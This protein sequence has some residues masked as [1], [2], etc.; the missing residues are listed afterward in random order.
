MCRISGLAP[1]RRWFCSKRLPR[2]GRCGM[3][4]NARFSSTM[5]LLLA[6]AALLT[7]AVPARAGDQVPWV[8]DFQAACGMAAEQH[9]LVLLH[10]YNDNCGPC[11]RVD[12]NVFSRPEVVEAVV[13]NYVAVKVHAGKS[14]Q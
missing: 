12:Q 6:A 1:A 11:V 4:L 8:A 3:M 13:L 9:R 10:F 5:A 14:P 7:A 2:S